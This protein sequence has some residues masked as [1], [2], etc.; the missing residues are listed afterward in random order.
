[1]STG[2]D[3]YALERAVVGQGFGALDAHVKKWDA[4]TPDAEVGPWTLGSMRAWTGKEYRDL[5]ALQDLVRDYLRLAQPPRPLC[6]AVFGPPGSGKSYA[7][8]QIG[9]NL[10][11]ELTDLDLPLV[12]LNLTQ[13]ASPEQLGSELRERT[14]VGGSTS[15]ASVPLVFFDE[16]DA[17]LQGVPLGWLSWFLAP[18]Q[19]GVF[20]DGHQLRPLKRAIYVFAGGTASRMAD[21]GARQGERFRQAKGPDFVSRLRGYLDVEGP[22][23][24]AARTQRRAV[25]I[26]DA[27]ERVEDSRTGTRSGARVVR[28][29]LL[30]QLLQA[31]RFRHGARSLHAVLEMAAAAS[32]RGGSL[33]V[34]EAKDLPP[35]H[36][37]AEHVDL[38]PLDPDLVG[39]PVA[40]SGGG[41]P[42][43]SRSS[44][45]DQV[46][47]GL[48]RAVWEAGGA[49]SYGGHSGAGGLT[50]LL[51]HTLDHFPAPLGGRGPATRL[52][53]YDAY[54]ADDERPGP[55]PDGLVRMRI[56]ADGHLWD[57]TA[58]PDELARPAQLFRMRWMESQGAI[59]RIALSGKAGLQPDGTGERYE[60]RM[61]GVLEEVLLSLIQGRPVYIIGGLGGC[62]EAVGQW[63][64]LGGR[65]ETPV[66]TGPSEKL[67]RV[68][69]TLA[70]RFQPGGRTDLP[71]VTQDAIDLLS[72]FA[73]GGSRWPDNGLSIAENRE[74]YEIR[75]DDGPA[76]VEL[77][78]RVA[79]IV[80]LVS[81]GLHRRFGQA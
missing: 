44:P 78:T 53:W 52:L 10:A 41:T 62:A 69:V 70:H 75:L 1:M 64:G 7:V 50:D 13:L 76:D 28:D 66:L 22:N 5:V 16:F 43:P 31:G 12:E 74:L 45:R 6:L 80:E 48:A 71:L 32:V 9:K 37:L 39:G 46:W 47:Q 65:P 51:A 14:L 25:L 26:R 73:V 29:D 79:R 67:A 54:K 40:M 38:G 35:P 11:K 58:S 59:A 27:L 24:L 3:K 49:V 55:P 61:P 36:L 15:R 56:P 20:R 4:H 19:D 63:L 30:E 77:V 42:D 60:G 8:K 18:M 72:G 33:G 57:D 17:P 23:A 81:T 2:S 34:I 21:F 68:V